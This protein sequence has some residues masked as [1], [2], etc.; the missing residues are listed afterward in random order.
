MEL[1]KGKPK[2]RA[3]LF[4][5]LL[6]ILFFIIFFNLDNIFPVKHF[7]VADI[8]EYK[9]D[10]PESINTYRL[11]YDIYTNK[12]GISTAG[13]KEI[14][15]SLSKN[16]IDIALITDCVP[17]SSS[18]EGIYGNK[19]ILSKCNRENNVVSY[20]N[21]IIS[22]D[23]SGCREIFNLTKSIKFDIL[24]LSSLFKFFLFQLFSLEKAYSQLEDFVNF[25]IDFDKISSNLCYISG[26]GFYSRF[27]FLNGK[28]GFS[29][30]NVDYTLPIV[31]N[32][33]YTFDRLNSNLVYSKDLVFNAIKNG[34]L[35]S[36]FSK[37]IDFDVFVKETNSIKPVGSLVY[38]ENNP[39]IF[40]NSENKDIL[41]AVYK[42]GYLSKVFEI[43][44]FR[45][46]PESEG[47][48][49]FI[50]YRYT[51]KLPFGIYTGV[52]PVAFL[53]SVFVQ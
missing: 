20:G 1:K 3:K 15:K 17:F 18:L 28:G 42:N 53:G 27:T 10:F 48:Y 23:S 32:K 44:S 31:I 30:L 24:Y 21:L 22:N 40:V 36:I 45:L 34:N 29:L 9:S 2:G 50:A 11:V 12:S 5:F 51:M 47:F 26:V 37:D 13:E 33:I 35:I 38:I 4:G 39:E 49:T 41:I 19:V 7:S 46:K 14:L 6:F 43:S 25:D 8:K 16:G 52:R